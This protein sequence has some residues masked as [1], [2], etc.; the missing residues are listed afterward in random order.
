MSKKMGRR[1]IG[2]LVRREKRKRKSHNQLVNK[3]FNHPETLGFPGE[4]LY[5][6][7]GPKFGE[8]NKETVDIVL[9]F[10]E[11]R[12]YNITAIEVKIGSRFKT[13]TKGRIQLNIAKKYFK[14]NWK[15]WIELTIG[16]R[17]VWYYSVFIYPGAAI[18]I[19]EMTQVIAKIKLT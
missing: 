7:K 14:K 8:K 1:G 11:K 18:T 9:L 16:H 12:R 13:I 2:R 6:E 4:V 5:K 15:E 17:E 3:I 19:K 10:A